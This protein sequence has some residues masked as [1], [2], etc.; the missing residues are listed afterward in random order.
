MK[1]KFVGMN[2]FCSVLLC[3][4]AIVLLSG[5]GSCDQR[6]SW[7]KKAFSERKLPGFSDFELPQGLWKKIEEIGAPPPLPGEEKRSNSPVARKGFPTEFAP[8]KVYLIERNRGILGRR[9]HAI[10]FG[11]GGGEIDLADFVAPLN[12]S[13]YFAAEF[14]ADVPELQPK[15]FFL[16][17]GIRRK[18]K[19]GE[20]S[21]GAGC[22]VYLDMSSAFANAMKRDGIVLNTTEARHV[23]VMAGTYFFVAVHEGKLH[24]ASLHVKD[25]SR[26]E[27]QCRN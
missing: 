24:L 15:I 4:F 12:G 5:I 19:Q 9:N 25:S 6:P 2:L 26:R 23:S 16:S 3:V 20:E 14:L 18:S 21:L 7:K 22:D 13:F 17:N 10:S 27:L 1:L 11:N 8:L